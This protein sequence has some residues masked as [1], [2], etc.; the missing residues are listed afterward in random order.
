MKQMEFKLKVIFL[1]LL[2]VTPFFY[3]C[4]EP[5]PYP[6]DSDPYVDEQDNPEVESPED[7]DRDKLL[8]LVNEVRSQGC[9]CGYTHY[10]PVDFVVW[11]DDLEEAAQ[12]HC[13]DMD[14]NGFFSHTGSDGSSPGDRL[15][16]V[17]YDWRAYGENIAMGYLTEDSV[18]EGW[19]NSPGHCR[20]I[21]SPN[22]SEM[23]VAKRGDYWTQVFA[24]PY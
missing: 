9:M 21:M 8:R 24:E 18:I 7:I 11:N 17:G 14:E 10:A 22:V 3:S 6:D 15:Y 23:G 4:G 20:N 1:F 19:L 5:E 13:D 2:F 16:D 12:N